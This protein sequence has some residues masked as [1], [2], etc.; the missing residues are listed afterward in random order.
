LLDDAHDFRAMARIASA[1]ISGVI[2]RSRSPVDLRLFWS[3][4]VYGVGVAAAL[5]NTW[6][7]HAWPSG[8]GA[9]CAPNPPLLLGEAKPDR[10]QAVKAVASASP[11]SGSALR[12]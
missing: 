6:L 12:V 3:L 4:A 10:P 5:P 7:V 2:L 8:L 11:R 1:A 9:L